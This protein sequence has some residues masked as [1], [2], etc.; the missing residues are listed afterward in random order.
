MR[1][2]IISLL[3][4]FALGQLWANSAV[5][6]GVILNV[7]DLM[8]RVEKVYNASSTFQADFK[9][10]FLNRNFSEI[11]SSGE[12]YFKRPGKMKWV[13]KKPSKKIIVSSGSI[14]WIYD[15]NDSQ[16]VRDKNFKK[17][18]LPSSLSFLWGEK[19]LLDVFNYKLLSVEEI[20]GKTIYTVE[21]IPKEKI[22]NVTRVHFVI[23]SKNYKIIETS[24]FDLFGNENRLLFKDQKLG[25]RIKDS[26]FEFDPPKGVEIVD[27]PELKR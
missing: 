5:K 20:S 13:Y 19:M 12:V 8:K 27:P 16:A 15:Y 25:K 23:D 18:M 24:L 14:L 17:E 9:Q 10:I 2:L 6:K 1:L 7:S 22:P 26:F 11:S 4:Y 21:L 3:T